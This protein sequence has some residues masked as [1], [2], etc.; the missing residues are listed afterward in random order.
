M[1]TG[2]RLVGVFILLIALINGI[3]S[4]RAVAEL[5]S[6]YSDWHFSWK[7]GFMYWTIG[8]FAS[9]VLFALSS[10]IEQLSFLSGRRKPE[11]ETS[12]VEE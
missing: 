4:G 5:S 6:A 1:V 9:M 7:T 11:P 12:Y 3:S 8:L 10:I 2:L